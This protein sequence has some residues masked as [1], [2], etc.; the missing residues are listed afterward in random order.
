MKKQKTE[1]PWLTP[2]GVEIKTS[3]LR[4]IA[5]SWELKTW[6]EY[7]DWYSSSQGERLVSQEVYEKVGNS[8]SESIFESFGHDPCPAKQRQCEQIL[9]TIRPRQAEVLRKIYL[10][11]KT[12]V[13]AAYELGRS[14]SSVAQLKNRGLKSI[15]WGNSG[16]N[17]LARHLVRGTS[18]SDDSE[19]PSLWDKKFATK[20]EEPKLYDQK[21]YRDELLNHPNQT[22]ANAAKT[23]TERQL[24][25]IYLRHWC[26]LSNSQIARVFSVGVN[27]AQNLILS[28]VHKFKQSV[29][30]IEA[31]QDSQGAV[32]Q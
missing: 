18:F 32:C 30:E 21:K 8:I 16:N 22:I 3:R 26:G 12:Q 23:L 5:K 25:A 13:V 20:I 6:N 9:S 28:A 17:L 1:R 24:R 31:K 15:K 19:S 27:T 4:E 14:Q 10:E 11:G 29:T 2:T 7:L